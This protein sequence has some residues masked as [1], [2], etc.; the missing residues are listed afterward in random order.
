MASRSIDDL[1]PRIR[2]GAK[3]VLRAWADKGID[4]IVTCTFRSMEEQDAL[5]RK[6]RDGVPGPKV[7]NAKPGQSKHNYGLAIDFV[8]LVNG[9]AVWDAESPL[10][11]ILARIAMETDSRVTWGGDWKGFKDRPHLEWTLR[12]E[13]HGGSAGN[14]LPDPGASQAG[15]A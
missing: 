6:G 10:W 9:K 8:P 11:K 14:T 3:A 12:G 13:Q 2:D 4:V 15:R 7:T 5:Y 1:D